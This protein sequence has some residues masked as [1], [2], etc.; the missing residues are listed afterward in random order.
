MEHIVSLQNYI[1]S[2]FVKHEPHFKNQGKTG[3]ST[4]YQLCQWIPLGNLTRIG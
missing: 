2:N 1:D 3:D 4:K